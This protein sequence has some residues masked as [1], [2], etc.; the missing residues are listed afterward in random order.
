MQAPK[1]GCHIAQ[2]APH[3]HAPA[4]LAHLLAE[5]VAR[6]PAHTALVFG[7]RE[8][9]YRE[10]GLRVAALARELGQRV[11]RGGIVAAPLAN[12]PECVVTAFAA[13]AAGLRYAPLNPFYGRGELA[14]LFAA[15]APDII[16]HN[17]D[18]AAAAQA[19]AGD[20]GGTALL[21]LD[22]AAPCED[23]GTDPA[24]A[25]L[26]VCPDLSPDDPAL[27]IFTG[28]TTG[29]SKAVEHSHAG[30]VFSV[31]AHCTGWELRYDEERILDVA[32]LFHIW[33]FG[34]ATLAP[35][36]LGSTL[37]LLPRYQPEQV[38]QQLQRQR[39]TVFAGGPAPIYAGL[40][41]SPEFPDTDLSHLT[42]A[43]TGGSP[44]PQPLREAWLQKV[45]TPLLEGWG[46]SEG[47]PLVFNWRARAQP[48]S[49]V[50]HPAPGIELRLVD[51]TDP[52]RAVAAGETGEVCVRG[53]QV[54]RGYRLQENAA[55]TGLDPDGWLHSGDIGYLD[56]DGY[57]YLVDRKKEMILVGGYNVYPRQVEDHIRQYPD[58]ADVAVV[59]I[60]D[61]Q[62]GENPYAFV[63]PRRGVP[64]DVDAL[65]AWC[66][67]TLVKYKRPV[68]IQV[69]D[70]LPR[71]GAN[72]LDKRRL[73]EILKSA[74]S[75]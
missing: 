20:T 28:G 40:M 62:L 18:S 8:T 9:S 33:G 46:M 15:Q 68:G 48:P 72:K 27:L 75:G 6:S 42:L 31:R 74:S 7:E 1:S 55:E 43:L 59:G 50:G 69:L 39:A 12:S 57:L 21:E 45:G 22:A 16:V 23:D 34:F 36:Y 44:C 32:P 73:R 2:V 61:P 29:L 51:V 17:R 10:L 67:Q 56:Q 41:A 49:S 58:V 35:L 47:A 13:F 26:A 54:M 3:L 64:I 52:S 66:Q 5:S 37:I 24:E 60:P 70:D 11:P 71:T 63:V 14:A 53:P 30:M 65:L 25:I 4:T 38:L 19:L